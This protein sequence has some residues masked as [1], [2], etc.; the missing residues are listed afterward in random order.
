[1][2]I[3]DF[4]TLLSTREDLHPDLERYH[5]PAGESGL[6]FA[7]VKHPLIF[8][9]PHAEELNAL[10]NARYKVIREVAEKCKKNHE[11]AKYIMCHERA[12]RVEKFW[13]LTP[14]FDNKAYWEIIGQLWMDSE[15]IYEMMDRWEKLLFDPKRSAYRYKMMDPEDRAT[16]RTLPDTIEIYRGTKNPSHQG[17]SWTTDYE[18]AQKF[19]QRY[20]LPGQGCYITKGAV[21]KK[22]VIAYLDARSEREV[23]TH[24]KN[25]T[26]IETKEIE[27][28]SWKS[29]Y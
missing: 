17:F 13:N 16:L 24:W 7:V 3:P 11:W 19:A 2:Q 29:Q 21:D 20:A 5:W 25:V 26:V 12:W 10:V 23:V 22:N 9:V 28:D 4:K 14:K 6:S 18:V 27:S 1:M 8:S 15:N